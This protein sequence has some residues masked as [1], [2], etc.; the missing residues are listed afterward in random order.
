[1]L[2]LRLRS[3][4]VVV[5]L[6]LLAFSV[7]FVPSNALST[8]SSINTVYHT[9]E[10]SD[11]GLLL[12]N[13]TLT[14]TNNLPSQ[15][16]I[17]EV[18]LYYPQQYYGN[19]FLN[20]ISDTRFHGS[21]AKEGNLTVLSLTPLEEVSLNQGESYSLNVLLSVEGCV[22]FK[23]SS[24]VGVNLVLYPGIS[25]Q[26]KAI[27][28]TIY[29]PFA[30]SFQSLEGYELKE[31]PLKTIY[32][33]RFENV[34]TGSYNFMNATLN[35]PPASD[36]IV[37]E[38]PRAERTVKVES[39]GSVS[40]IDSLEIRNIDNKSITSIKLDLLN[41]NVIKVKLIM[42]IGPDE[43]VYLGVFKQFTPKAPI[44]YNRSYTFKME[45]PAPADLVKF[46][47]GRY[48][49]NITA[50]PPINT[51]VKEYVI[52]V[53]LSEGVNLLSE[54][55]KELFVNSSPFVKGRFVVEYEPKLFWSSS[56]SVP[57]AL[58]ILI[59]LLGVFSYFQ[60][61]ETEEKKFSSEFYNMV[62]DKLQLVNS[63]IDLYEERRLGRV[64][65]QKFNILK[66][67]YVARAGSLNN[68]LVRTAGELTKESPEKAARVEKV[69]NLNREL[70]QALKA[71]VN[72]YDL[73][74]AGRINNDMFQKR[75]SSSAKKIDSIRKDIEDEIGAL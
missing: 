5:L 30:T 65:K 18:K 15:A 24:S 70:D 43:E 56:T 11:F 34:T 40:I 32:S 57:V 33:K 23:E 42:P 48:V 59:L 73:L 68:S 12:V 35:L 72:D 3:L 13:E 55:D 38:V 37:V 44:E 61:G 58:M 64:P 67:E 7:S 31:T 10:V 22:H 27:E 75:R 6:S 36:M 2:T 21:F 17:P 74:Q 39:D 66:Q 45:Y 25:L 63:T 20:L 69:L 16:A 47:N 46:Y 19:I 8:I 29:T 53:E 28:S 60:K 54:V 41:P 71:L 51:L 9:L 1:M 4:L 49:V 52:R 62:Q 14:I 50:S 26:S